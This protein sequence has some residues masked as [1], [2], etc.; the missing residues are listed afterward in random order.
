MR[1]LGAALV[2]STVACGGYEKVTRVYDGKVVDGTFIPPDAYASYL[3]G[4][5]AEESGDLPAARSAF[6]RAAHEDDDPEILARLGE[7]R[8]KSDPNDKKADDFFAKALKLDPTHA[9]AMAALGRCALLRGQDEVALAQA[10][11]A[12]A[13]DPG[14]ANLDALLVKA[15]AKRGDAT[16]RDRILELTKQHGERVVAWDALIAWA[17][18]RHDAPLLAQGFVGLL[19]VAPIRSAEVEQGAR[20]LL[21][22]GDK[23]FATAVAVAIADSRRDLEVRGPKDPVVARLAVDEALAR[24]D[25]HAAEARATR[26]HIDVVEVAARAALLG[27][28]DLA[29]ALASDLAAA[30]PNTGARSLDAASWVLHQGQGGAHAAIVPHDPLVG[31]AALE[32][33]ARGVIPTSDLGADERVELAARRGEVPAP[34]IRTVD[35]D[36]RH[37]L[38]YLA[39][40]NASEARVTFTELAVAPD[41]VIA[42]A[43]AR[44]TLADGKSSTETLSFVRRTSQASTNPLA[45]AAAKSLGL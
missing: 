33:A 28:K 25:R 14:N 17:R 15:Q 22:N 2:L 21:G 35:L 10:L 19:Q 36:A 32:L 39:L 44:I 11:K 31:P 24:G 12:T 8:C 43:G 13:A 9:G 5:L 6:E 23:P 41:P 4:V 40:T 34:S 26:G 18:G 3:R 7:V 20:E 30:D 42:F 45:I 27:Q 29:T 1:L 37:H 38:L 16:S